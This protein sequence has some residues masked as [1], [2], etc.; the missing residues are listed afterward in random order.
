MDNAKTFINNKQFR[1]TLICVTWPTIINYGSGFLARIVGR[2]MWICGIISIFTTLFFIYLTIY[3]GR[4]FPDKTIVEYGSDLL[5]SVLGKLL[6]LILAAYFFVFSVNSVSMYIHHLTSFLLPQTPFL[7]VTVIHVLVI[8]YFL[9]EGPEVIARTGVIGFSMA[10]VFY[11]LVF[12]GSLSEIDIDRILPIFDSGIMPVFQASIKADT[13]I[14]VLPMLIAMLLPMVRDQKRAFRTAASGLFIGGFFFVFYFIM[15]LMVMGSQLVAL[16][17]IASMD[18]VRSIQITKYLHRFES[19]MVAL[20]Y[21]S[22]LVQAG[23][24]AYC[25]LEAFMQTTGIKKKKPGI[26]I[27]FG[28]LMVILTYYIGYDKVRFLILRE[29]IWQYISLPIQYGFPIL[30][31]LALKIKKVLSPTKK[32]KLFK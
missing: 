27:V 22:I 30:L 28:I 21:W 19:F 3:I 5:G 4:N 31:F 2:D 15:E 29:Y 13:F 25:S 14:G 10:V 24:L 26:I 16:M 18:F 32:K 9:L 6:G 1:D 8:C 17:R 20:W 23:I 7:V 12:M 11:S